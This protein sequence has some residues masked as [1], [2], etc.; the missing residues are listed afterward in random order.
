MESS[1]TNKEIRWFM[2]LAYLDDSGTTGKKLDD[3]DS[4]YQ[5]VTALLL[6]DE[7][8]NSVEIILSTI[9]NILPDVCRDS[10]REF[11][12]HDLF[13]GKRVFEK[14]DVEKRHDVLLKACRIV[15]G[16][17]IPVF[18]GAV[19]KPRLNATEFASAHPLDVAFQ[20]CALGV[21]EWMRSHTK[22][23]RAFENVEI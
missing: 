19:H 11:K 10:F 4:P 7:Q 5:I 18:Y 13:W 21:E 16:I 3:P 12:A 2:Y 22:C 20:H 9:E 1:P 17:R 15:K 6:K 14:V 8:F 23:R